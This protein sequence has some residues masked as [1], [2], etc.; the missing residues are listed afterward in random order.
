MQAAVDMMRSVLNT[1][2]MDGVVVIG[3]GEKDEVS[4]C[5]ELQSPCRC[6]LSERSYCRC[7]RPAG[8]VSC[9]M[10]LVANQLHSQQDC[11]SSIHKAWRIIVCCALDVM[12]KQAR[13]PDSKLNL[14]H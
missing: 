6:S 2:N 5:A 10:S 8:V 7:S 3:E 1:V 14:L 12:L 4:H 13:P 11:G 9:L